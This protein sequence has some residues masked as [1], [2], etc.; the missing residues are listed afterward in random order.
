LRIQ[1]LWYQQLR[2]KITDIAMQLE[3]SCYRY[4]RIADCTAL[5]QRIAKRLI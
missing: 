4:R 1:I 5:E 2:K 3:E